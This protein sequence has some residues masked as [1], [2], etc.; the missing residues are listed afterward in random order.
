MKLES[1]HVL[2]FDDVLKDYENLDFLRDEKGR[3]QYGIVDVGWY[4]N[5]SGDLHHYDGTVWDVVP[6]Q[7]VQDL[8]FLGE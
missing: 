4:Q 7:R 2:I 6:Q 1:D 5:S 3:F 8:E